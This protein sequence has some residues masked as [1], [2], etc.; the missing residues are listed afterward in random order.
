MGNNQRAPHDYWRCLTVY[1]I[2]MKT[3]VSVSGDCLEHK[4]VSLCS[5]E[6]LREVFEQNSI[7]PEPP[8]ECSQLS[9][10]KVSN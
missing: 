3:S 10:C 4:L 2:A 8:Q 7:D 1:A 6:S 9:S 5:G